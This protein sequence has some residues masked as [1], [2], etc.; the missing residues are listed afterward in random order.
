M[1]NKYVD[2]L[3]ESKEYE[4]VI[5]KFIKIQNF[6]KLDLSLYIPFGYNNI[7]VLSKKVIGKLKSVV[8]YFAMY[9]NIKDFNIRLFVALNQ[10][11]KKFPDS[12]I[13]T[14][15]NVNNGVTTF[16]QNGDKTIY[17]YRYED[18]YK[19]LIHEMIHYF[20]FD[21]NHDISNNHDLPRHF[22]IKNM[23]NEIKLT[24]AYTETMACYLY[25]KYLNRRRDSAKTLEAINK[26]KKRF[27]RITK[28]LIIHFEEFPIIEEHSHM[29][30]YLYC[31]TF[32]FCNIGKFV[33]LFNNKLDN[34]NKKNIML[35]HI[36]SGYE[37]FKK[38]SANI[39][40]LKSMSSFNRA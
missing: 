24:E 8:T 17:I 6:G 18:L 40:G 3:L 28:A 27:C 15:T 38:Y 21:I 14:M 5:H 32:L 34:E 29:F 12:N 35:N 7:D 31:R 26:Y 13:V 2:I 25:I 4:K 16:Y 23:D 11:R 30:A 19:V 9:F 1:V 33:K 10:E 39:K 37:Y 22:K 36:N 20:G